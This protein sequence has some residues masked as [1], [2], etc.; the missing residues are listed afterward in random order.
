MRDLRPIRIVINVLQ[1]RRPRLLLPRAGEPQKG[2]GRL[3]RTLGHPDER[4]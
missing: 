1:V 4:M 3:D 2:T